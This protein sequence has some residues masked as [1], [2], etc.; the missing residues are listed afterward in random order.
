MAIFSFGEDIRQSI[1]FS[2]RMQ[3][4]LL[5]IADN[6]GENKRLGKEEVNLYFSLYFMH[7]MLYISIWL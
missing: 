4:K 2:R 1:L 7:F 5:H 3:K 6:I